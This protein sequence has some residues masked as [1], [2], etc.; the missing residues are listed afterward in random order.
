MVLLFKKIVDKF[1]LAFKRKLIPPAILRLRNIERRDKMNEVTVRMSSLP[2]QSMVNGY[3]YTF[4]AINNLANSCSMEVEKGR[5]KIYAGL[6][7][8][9]HYGDSIII[10]PNEEF[11][12]MPKTRL[13]FY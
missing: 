9:I 2:L 4:G 7:E 3:I 12:D 5:K 13:Y 11:P 10:R 8:D 6:V 1:F